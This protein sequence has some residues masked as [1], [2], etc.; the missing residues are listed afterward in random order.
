MNL[1]PQVGRRSVYSWKEVCEFVGLKRNQ[2]KWIV[3]TGRLVKR[4]SGLFPFAQKDVNQFL[5]RLNAGE[6]ELGVRNRKEA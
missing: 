4:H 6:I 3:H 2:L 1:I 5:V